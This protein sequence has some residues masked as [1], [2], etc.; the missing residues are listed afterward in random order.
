LLL[1]ADAYYRAA[2]K[3]EMLQEEM[4]KWK[5]VTMSADFPPNEP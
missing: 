3:I 1:G 5:S 2:K 4:A